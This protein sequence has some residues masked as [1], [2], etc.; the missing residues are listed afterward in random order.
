MPD[1]E[2]SPRFFLIISLLGLA[3]LLLLATAPP[4]LQE[5]CPWRRPVVGTIFA[6]ICILGSFAAVS[7]RSCKNFLRHARKEGR[8]RDLKTSRG[9]HP[10]CE[11]FSSHVVQLNGLCLCAG[12][13]GLFLGAMMALLGTVLYFFLGLHVYVCESS[14]CVLLGSFGV[15]LGLIQYNFRGLGRVLVN[16]IF[17]LASFFILSSVDQLVKSIFVD[18]FVLM[19][20]LFWILT[21]IRI[22]EYEHDAICRDCRSKNFGFCEQ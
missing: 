18:L 19:L 8:A 4:I 21:R 13:T 9:H 3:I 5:S 15:L 14:L 16:A 1:N 17:V 6:T 20:I 2:L 12:C 11:E 22:S 10:P 7:P